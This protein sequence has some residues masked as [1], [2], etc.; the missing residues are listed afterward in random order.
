MP[1]RE[2]REKYLARKMSTYPQEM[3]EILQ[4]AMR[5]EGYVKTFAEHNQAVGF[6][7]KFYRFRMDAIEAG[8][9]GALALR[10]LTASGKD[11]LGGLLNTR[12]PGAGGPYTVTWIHSGMATATDY[13]RASGAP[14]RDGV[15][16]FLTHALGGEKSTAREI[17]EE[18]LKQHEA[19]RKDVELPADLNQ[20]LCEHEWDTTDTHCLKCKTPKQ[21]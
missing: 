7:A 15:E 9:T 3:F 16:D 11:S 12:G 13:R 20:A 2:T 5:G 17:S 6:T 19:Q 14:S 10:E 1:R 21:Q 8:M 4:C 18:E